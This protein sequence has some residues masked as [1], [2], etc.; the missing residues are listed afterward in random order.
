VAANW[1]EALSMVGG[2][3]SEIAALTLYALPP[4]LHRERVATS[5]G[6]HQSEDILLRS[7]GNGKQHMLSI[8]YWLES[9]VEQQGG[10]SHLYQSKESQARNEEQKK[11]VR[12]PPSSGHRR[13]APAGGRPRRCHYVGS[14]AVPPQ[15]VQHHGTQPQS[16]NR[17]HRAPSCWTVTH[18][19]LPSRNSDSEMAPSRSVKRDLGGGRCS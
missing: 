3:H 9:I 6:R 14:Y 15:C 16:V 5:V 7:V 11:S 18:Q 2:A 1:L 12:P 13:E 10:T 19:G 8:S 17:G 4:D